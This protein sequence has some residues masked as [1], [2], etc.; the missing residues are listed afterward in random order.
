MD[1]DEGFIVGIYNYCDR[2]CESC[3]FTSR[4]R[5]F[6]DGA[7]HEAASTPELK[8]LREVP[9]HPSDVRPV[10][11]WFDDVL[12]EINEDDLPELPIPPPMPGHLRRISALSGRYCD[13]AWA[14]I[15]RG[16]GHDSRPPEDPRS[17]ILWF[18]PLISSKT[19]RALNGLHEFDG[20]RDY[21][22][23]HEGSAKVV[24][25]GIDR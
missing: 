19:R 9:K 20:C 6:A 10:R 13:H 15:E 7:M 17:I 2:W 24:L 18:A 11:G 14:A 21:P 4:C 5:V 22:P 12:A 3:R 25:I 23:D 1:V 16:E 8:E